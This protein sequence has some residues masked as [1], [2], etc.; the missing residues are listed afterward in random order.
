MWPRYD[1]RR[2]DAIRPR[3]DPSAASAA[4]CWS[5]AAAA[6]CS[7]L[8]VLSAWR[9]AAHCS[10]NFALKCFQ[11][12]PKML[13]YLCFDKWPE[14]SSQFWRMCKHYRP[15]L[16]NVTYLKK[17]KQ[18]KLSF[19]RLQKPHDWWPMNG[20]QFCWW[21]LVRLTFC[22]CEITPSQGRNAPNPPQPVADLDPN[23]QTIGV[24][25]RPECLLQCAEIDGKSSK[26]WCYNNK[27]LPPRSSTSL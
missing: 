3:F 13:D 2:T 19:L 4:D 16:N 20:Q 21:I 6:A 12:M 11:K 1:D 25:K 17:T 18:N 14:W 7:A 24:K 5:R 10:W 27:L 26:S 22:P 9:K 23:K 15:I 8:R